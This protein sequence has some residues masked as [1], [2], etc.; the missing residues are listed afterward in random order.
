MALFGLI[1][2]FQ[3]ATQ[4]W[5]KQSVAEDGFEADGGGGGVQAVV[6][7]AG[8]IDYRII[9]SKTAFSVVVYFV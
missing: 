9:Y 1:I 4:E 7:G 2:D 3:A 6:F 5:R 8:H